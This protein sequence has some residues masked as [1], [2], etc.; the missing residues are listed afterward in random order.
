M[1]DLEIIKTYVNLQ[2]SQLNQ[3]EKEKFIKLMLKYRE[4]FSL[5][6]EIG[7]CPSM[8]IKLKL[9]DTTP[10]FIRPFPITEQE[11]IL[12]DREMRKGVMLGILR[13]GLSSYS[14]TIM[15]IP[16]KLGGIPRTV[17]DFRHLNSILY[18]L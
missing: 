10:F 4:A 1:T 8:E 12:V 14:S 11:K 6:D 3:T 18:I 15:L 5:R 13:R 9:N 16:R 2:G 7:K 17:T